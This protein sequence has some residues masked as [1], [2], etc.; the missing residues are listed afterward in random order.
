MCLFMC[1][2]AICTSSSVQCHF[3]SFAHF[4][5]WLFFL[6]LSFKNSLYILDTSPLSIFFLLAFSLSFHPLPRV[7]LGMKVFHFYEVQFLLLWTVLL[8]SSFKTLH[9]ILDSPRFYPIFPPK[10]NLVFYIGVCDAFWVNFYIRYETGSRFFSFPFSFHVCVSMEVHRL[11]ATSWKLFFLR[12][13]LWCSRSG[14]SGV[15][16]SAAQ[17]TAVV[18]VQVT[19]QG[20]FHILW[21]QPKKEK[22]VF[23]SFSTELFLFLCQKSIVHICVGPLVDS[24]YCSIDLFVYHCRYHTGLNSVATEHLKIG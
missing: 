24:L 1:L 17:V 15:V 8:M 23:F 18:R 19:G 11:S 22:K 20:N 5:I 9:L 16:T 4:L 21:A 13:L 6:P 2:F 3:R 12:V 10:D 14:T 7:F